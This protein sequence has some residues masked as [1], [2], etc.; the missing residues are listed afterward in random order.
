[1]K[2]IKTIGI[3]GGGQLGMM[4]C[5][6]ARELGYKTA[7]L[8]PAERPSA[9]YVCDH[10][11]QGNFDD[12]IALRHLATLA[13]V[14]TYEFEN[15]PYHIVQQLITEGVYIPQ[16][17][18]P[19]YVTQHRLR[20]KNAIRAANLPTAPFFAVQ[21]YQQLISAFEQL[22]TPAILKTCFGG[23]DGKGQWRIES[24]TDA[25]QLEHLF[26]GTTEYV[27]EQRLLL[28]QEVSCVVTC[29]TN[30]DLQAF[31]LGENVH[32]NGIL[33][34]TTAPA[35]LPNSLAAQATQMAISLMQHLGFVGTL[36]VELFIDTNNQIYIN[37][38]APRPHNS[39]HHTIEACNVSQY[40]NH[41]H[42]ITGQP[43]IVPKLTSA[44]LMLNIIGD[45]YHTL[46]QLFT[47]GHFHDY[48][49]TVK[50]NRKMAH[51]TFLGDDVAS[52]KQQV[53]L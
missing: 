24:Q 7:V 6:A 10:Y 3:I 15:I 53:G 50:P 26:D 11:V 13:D 29:S 31:P 8:D 49:K 4:L 42:A 30:G 32:R 17:E 14:I 22:G 16:T 48:H 52:L 33:H 37:E 43:L 9:A 19:L 35:N 18:Q 1:M 12:I 47:K 41:I 28:A 27:L 38:L 45:E 21:N 46:S 39:G 20:E 40:A 23:Y 34:Y 51:I 36:A 25:Q 5:E 44:T 2:Q